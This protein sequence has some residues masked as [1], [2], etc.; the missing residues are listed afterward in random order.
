M[1]SANKD[2][3]DPID[4]LQNGG[5]SV[6]QETTDDVS[7]IWLADQTTLKSALAI[8]EADQDGNNTAR[9][10]KIYGAQELKV[11]FG[12]PAQGR[13]PDII[14]Q[15]IPGTIYSGS[16][17]KIAEH[18]GFAADDTHVMLVVS[19]PKLEARKVHHPVANKQVAPTILK[20]L[21]LNPSDLQAVRIEHTRVL[22]GLVFED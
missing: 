14:I 1:L 20:S 3:V 21:G 17:K 15:P 4:L 6:A 8:L 9:I 11:K 10:Q 7:L 5:V 2:V 18:G 12:D 13:A 22:P 16:A 19:N